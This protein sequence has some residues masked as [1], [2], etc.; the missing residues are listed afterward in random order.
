[1]PSIRQRASG[2]I[3]NRAGASLS[4]VVLSSPA[5]STAE[6]GRTLRRASD[7]LSVQF[8]LVS[9]QAEPSWTTLLGDSAELVRAPFGS[10]RAEMC[11]LGMSKATGSIVAVRD[12]ADV[13]DATWI[14]AF[15]SVVPRRSEV[16]LPAEAVVMDS[17]MPHRATLAD[18]ARP[19][20]LDGRPAVAA[21]EMAAAG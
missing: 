6:V 18:V 9:P 7:D 14:A 21:I 12:A 20:E 4:V 13:G 19:R 3:A 5:V 10:T 15:R 2:T 8:V 16:P 1:M 17:M 11:D